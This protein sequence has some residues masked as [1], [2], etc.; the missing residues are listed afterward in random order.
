MF[1]S[2]ISSVDYVELY[3]ANSYQAAN[4]YKTVLGFDIVAYGGEETGLANKKSYII[5]Q[6]KIRLILS[7]PTEVNSSIHLHIMK[8]DDGVKDIA[9]LSENVN[10]SFQ[11]AIDNGA[12]PILYP[13]DI[14]EDNLTL[15]VASIA[16]FGETIHTFIQRKNNEKWFM[17]FYQSFENGKS[18]SSVGL[19]EIDHIAIALEKEQL[20]IWQKFYKD[21]LGFQITHTEDV[22]TEY[23]GMNSVVMSNST[24]NIKFPLVEPAGGTKKS[25]IENYLQHYSGAGVQHIAFLT[26]DIVSS[27]QSLKKKGIQFLNI[28]S[29]YYN[30]MSANLSNEI[31]EKLPLLK[32]LGILIDTDSSGTLMQIFSKPLQTRPTFFIELVERNNKEGFGSRNIKA[33]FEAIEKEQD[34][35][36]GL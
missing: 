24:G 14:G 16:C 10:E 8:H 26:N 13:I 32:E 31:K 6:G 27:T 34:K 5:E 2:I 22:H 21:T 18:N 23:S 29:S 36:K 1:N 33:L 19:Y 30:N 9:F 11:R 7:S 3:V 35:N 12:S 4:F 28:P 20:S 17:P 25:Q 15:K